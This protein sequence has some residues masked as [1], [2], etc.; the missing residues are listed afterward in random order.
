MSIYPNPVGNLLTIDSDTIIKEIK[1]LNVLGTVIYT[2]KQ[3]S[4][5]V[6]INLESYTSGVYLVTVY[7]DLEEQLKDKS[8]SFMSLLKINSKAKPRL[9]QVLEPTQSNMVGVL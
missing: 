1:I 3:K 9:I 6:I 7:D 8:N 4:N 2:P 5:K